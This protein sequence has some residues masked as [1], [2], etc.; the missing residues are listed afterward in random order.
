MKGLCR[1]NMLRG[2][3]FSLNGLLG[4]VLIASCMVSLP[5][6]TALPSPS[7]TFYAAVS[8]P[9]D[10]PIPTQTTEPAPTQTTE[11]VQTSTATLL[12]LIFTATPTPQP[13]RFAI[14]G[15][16]GTGGQPEADV[17]ALVKSWNPEFVITAG[18]NNYPSG[19]AESIDE[20]IGQFYHEF[21]YPYIGQYG[22]GAD[23]NRFYPSLGNHDWDSQ[24]AQPYLDY[25][26]LPG[27]ERYYEF[28]WGFL[29]FFALDSDSREPDG[30]GRSS[31]QA[32]W[33][34]ER[35]EAS[36]EPWN[37]V[38]FHHAPYSSGV[39]GSTD[40]MQWPFAEWGADLVMAGHDHTYERIERDEIVYL[41][42]GLGGAPIYSFGIPVEGSLVRYNDDYGALMIEANPASLMILFVNR[43]GETID[44][45]E[46][47]GQQFSN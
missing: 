25:F 41:V 10:I 35:L 4:S 43:S 2:L 15:D 37:I 11:P 21:I 16:Y 26:T 34:R 32:S 42:N 36:V 20:N 39:H 17:A 7:A 24:S 19:S 46:I 45:F 9:S 28:T 29:H 3:R 1:M 44:V 13:L 8:L 22:E 30:V 5:L 18:D 27:N 12:P 38:Y 33:L 6:N 14:I 40:W 31:T 47:I 23:M